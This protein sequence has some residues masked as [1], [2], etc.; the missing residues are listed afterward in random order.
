MRDLK[1]VALLIVF[2]VLLLMVL[3]YFFGVAAAAD[4]TEIPDAIIAPLSSNTTHIIE[5][6]QGAPDS[7]EI[8]YW[9]ET[10]DLTYIEGWYGLVQRVPGGEVV[11]VSQFSH[12][13]LV[14]PSVFP[15]GKWY[16]WS[17]EGTRGSGNNV[18]FE[19]RTG[20]RPADTYY[21]SNTT[22]G[23][24][25][26]IKRE[27]VENLPL[28][29]RRVAD[30][31]VAIGDHLNITNLNST[32]YNTTAMVWIFDNAT[33]GSTGDWM[34]PRFANMSL[35]ISSDEIERLGPGQYVVVVQHLNGNR[36][37]D[38]LFSN[39]TR[40]RTDNG[41]EEVLYSPFG[42]DNV[43]VTGWSPKMIRDALIKKIDNGTWIAQGP[44]A[45]NVFDDTYD[46]RSLEIQDQ[47][48]EIYG[49]DEYYRS[50]DESVNAS[51][52]RIFG[53]T[54]LKN[55]T[56]L[57][58]IIDY[59]KQNALTLQDATQT[60]TAVG[61]KI[62]DKRQFVILYPFYYRDL[63]SAGKS[64]SFSVIN[65]D[66]TNMTASFRVFD[67]NP[68]N[69][70]PKPTRKY[71]G[72]DEEFNPTTIPTIATVATPPPV[73]T[74]TVTV[75]VPVIKEVVKEVTPWY[76]TPGW[77]VVWILCAVILY[78]LYWRFFKK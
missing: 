78:Y 36:V 19:V 6:H 61:N 31:L 74:V 17:P 28:P 77:L 76:V 13:I 30:Y 14:A 51:I 12:R 68:D 5:V 21:V 9:G 67:E 75:P 69:P 27:P 23:A 56:V 63:S 62:G 49:I 29:S 26:E 35:N 45:Y 66:G 33:S 65:P 72:G 32:P 52:A 44:S 16:Q 8:I 42:G 38:V 53:Y 1:F 58:V 54:N 7:P 3:H 24:V 70:V 71:F 57:K 40:S 64:H 15:A 20:T 43:T 48:S 10:V 22:T 34:Y 73:V 18:A 55:A 37:A 59:D 4:A 2:A 50:P 47:Y 60:T 41:F 46:L 11:D 39:H 25:I